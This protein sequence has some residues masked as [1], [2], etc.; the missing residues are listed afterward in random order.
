MAIENGVSARRYHRQYGV[1][2]G[3]IGIWRLKISVKT[4]IEK[5]KPAMA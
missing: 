5:V 3:G 1:M 4:S 2:C